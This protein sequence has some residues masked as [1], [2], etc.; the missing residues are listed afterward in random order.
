MPP[1]M[2]D[3]ISTLTPSL[4]RLLGGGF[5]TGQLSLV[6][7]E[8]SSGKTTLSI[9]CAV[10]ASTKSLKTLYIDSDQSFS[11]QRLLQIAG[12][13]GEGA[14]EGIIIFLPQSFGEQ[15][16][17]VESLENYITKRVRLIVIDTVTSLYRVA[18][19]RAGG[20]F[21]L[22]RELN[23]Q[24]AYLAELAAE[25]NLVVLVTGQVRSKVEG[26]GWQIEPVARRTLLHWPRVILRLKQTAEQ[27][28]KEARLE[29]GPAQAYEQKRCYLEMTRSGLVDFH[30][31]DTW[32]P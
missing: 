32:S 23:R 13:R 2:M 9:Q 27:K 4:D 28:I 15:S 21:G 31:S 14:C 24:L 19:G 1:A 7:G 26:L 25:H 5:P 18:L 17:I 11:H 3:V 30:E 8:A 16:R 22:N 10:S 6:Y 20:S 29:R 12:G